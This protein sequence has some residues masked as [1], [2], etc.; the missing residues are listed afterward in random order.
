M[1][2]TIIHAAFAVMFITIVWMLVRL[3]SEMINGQRRYFIS[4]AWQF[5]IIAISANVVIWLRMLA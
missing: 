3:I 1:N 4:Y 2:E 5:A